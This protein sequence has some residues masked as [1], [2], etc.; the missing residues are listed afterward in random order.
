L[1]GR[2]GR[3]AGARTL[4]SI[5]LLDQ[6]AL[7]AVIQWEFEPTLLNGQPMP[8]TYN[9]TVAFTL[10]APPPPPLPPPPAAQ[11][12]TPDDWPADAVRV[13][14]AVPAPRKLTNVAPVYPQNAKAAQVEGV[15]IV[16][17]LI[18]RDGRVGDTQILRS[19]PLL[20]QAATDAVS[21]WTFEPTLLNGQPVPL[22]YNVTVTFTLRQ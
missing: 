22:I 2:D 1:I 9:V 20:D 10:A 21:Q 13:G 4:R 8:V 5:P 6:A 12:S 14:G 17:V 18:E 19:I 16:R 3:V 11:T 7:D 15:V